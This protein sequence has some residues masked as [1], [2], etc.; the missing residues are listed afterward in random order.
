MIKSIL[1]ASVC[2]GFASAAGATVN[3]DQGVDVKAAIDS[4]KASDVAIPAATKFP[5]L[6]NSTRDCK[7]ITFSATDPLTSPAVSLAS[8][9]QYQDCQNMG[10]YAGQ[11]CIPSFQNYRANAQIVV[12]QPRELK[13]DQK[14]VFEVCLWGSFLSMKPVSTVYSYSVYRMLDT[15]QITPN[16]PV[17]PGQNDDKSAVKAAPAQ[18]VCRLAMDDGHTCVYQCKDGSYISNPNPFPVIP[19]PNQWVGPIS[20]PCRPTVPNTPLITILGK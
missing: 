11:I 20:T 17:Q 5:M 4:A 15:F 3:F 19:A 14:E 6:I 2:F 9:E 1:I 16:G 7:K 18:D 13:P 12:T 10:P 8:Q